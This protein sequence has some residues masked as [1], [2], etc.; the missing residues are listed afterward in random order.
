MH[1]FG[2]PAGPP[3]LAIHGVYGSGLRFRRL[4]EEGIGEMRVV[5]PDLRG[6][7]HSPWEPPW[8]HETHVASLIGVL[9]ALGLE[10]AAVIGHS[11]GGLLAMRLAAAV[12]DR[13]SRLA[14]LDP[15]VAL[16][17]DAVEA[18]VA[19]CLEGTAWAATLADV[20]EARESWLAARP[21]EGRWALETELAQHLVA[22][23]GGL[24]W[25]FSRPAGICAWNA[26]ALPPPSLGGYAGPIALVVAARSDYVTPALERS[27]RA[28][29]GGRVERIV[30]DAGH[31]L[32]WDAVPALAEALDAFLAEAH[33]HLRLG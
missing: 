29:A 28:E 16:P 17:V 9:D 25:R 26:M 12:P 14:L 4:G 21:E 23:T 7:G 15:A 8:D 6:H 5:A 22:V 33:P 11:F 18:R 1:E 19:E 30:I 2:D 31:M 10:R 24:R 32:I 3:V 27:L 13:V 20:H